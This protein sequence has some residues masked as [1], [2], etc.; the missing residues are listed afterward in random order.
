[1][2]DNT[3]VISSN[4]TPYGMAQEKLLKNGNLSSQKSAPAPQ[5]D[6]RNGSLITIWSGHGA[7][8]LIN[9]PSVVA[10]TSMQFVPGQTLYTAPFI[11]KSIHIENTNNRITSKVFMN[12]NGYASPSSYNNTQSN[13]KMHS[14]T[15]ALEQE[16]TEGNIFVNTIR[17]LF[18]KVSDNLWKPIIDKT[19]MFVGTDNNTKRLPDQIAAKKML[20]SGTD[21]L[22]S[23]NINHKTNFDDHSSDSFSYSSEIS[24]INNNYN[25]TYFDCDEDDYLD[26]EDQIDFVAASTADLPVNGLAK[27]MDFHD[28]I[29]KSVV[30]EKVMSL[31]PQLPSSPSSPVN[32]ELEVKSEEEMELLEPEAEVDNID[33]NE[34]PLVNV[35]DETLENVQY[36]DDVN[37]PMKGLKNWQQNRS[38]YRRKRRGKRKQKNNGNRKKACG[39]NKNR[40]EKIRHE[41]EMNIHDDIDDC[42]IVKNGT[43]SFKEPDSNETPDSDFTII[44]MDENTPKSLTINKTTSIKSNK[45][46]TTDDAE[47]GCVETPIP[48]PETIPS[49]CIFTKFFRLGNRNSHCRQPP[50]SLPTRC[51]QKLYNPTHLKPLKERPVSTRRTS[52]TESDD[53]FIV[54][55]ECS[56]K[57]T[58]S[59]DDLMPKQS[60]FYKRQR[61]LSDCS[62]DFILFADDDDDDG[63]HLHCYTTDEDFTDS[64]D[65]SDGSDDGMCYDH[66]FSHNL[67]HNLILQYIISFVFIM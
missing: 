56:P 37:A 27:D 7:Q 15:S 14:D 18:R 2:M 19:T 46:T 20:W 23:H 4:G 26:G 24:Y 51:M 65:D 12:T 5:L 28:C 53:S 8:L 3:R 55:E 42:S 52:E 34:E 33:V 67:L 57:S 31:T 11:R 39:P 59:V 44:N 25:E 9:S 17:N 21:G 10:A 45:S 35:T 60:T 62:D 61:Q 22:V 50:L 1:M 16:S 32:A 13:T 63:S 64:T 38:S 29:N 30:D 43:V 36:L 49:G 58:T 6:T 48:S 41:V 66:R 40:H 54:F 47:G